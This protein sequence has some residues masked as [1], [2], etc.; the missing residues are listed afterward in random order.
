MMKFASQRKSMENGKWKMENKILFFIFHFPFSIMKSLYEND[1]LYD[2]VHEKPADS[3]QVAFYERQIKNYGSPV[4]ELACGTGNYLVTLSGEETEISGIDISEEM[5]H[6][7]QRRAQAKQSEPNLINAD[8]RE[9]DLEQEFKLIFIAGNSLQHLITNADVESC[10]ASV[11]KH[12]AANGRFIVE[13]FNPSLDLL[14][15]DP[16][17]RYYVGDYRTDQGLILLTENVL[18]DAATQ[19][20]HIR[21]HYRKQSDPQEHT[22]SFTMR[23]FFPLELDTLFEKN[24]FRIESKFGDFDQSDFSSDSPKQIIVASLM[25]FE[26][27]L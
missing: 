9:F 24:G 14:I 8:M 20:N 12:L 5:L 10:F 21:W 23:Q 26:S 13:V 7:A 25:R 22:V 27:T 17:E 1:W 19:V 18:Y 2:L 16:N 3:E 15:R 6:G 11:R 4:L